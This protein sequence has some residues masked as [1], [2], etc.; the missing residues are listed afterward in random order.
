VSRRNPTVEEEDIEEAFKEE[1]H[2]SRRRCCVGLCVGTVIGV[3]VIVIILVVVYMV[4]DYFNKVPSWIVIPAFPL[5]A[6]K[7]PKT[8]SST[9]DNRAN[10]VPPPSNKV[11]LTLVCSEPYMAY[12]STDSC[13]SMC[14]PGEC[15][16]YEFQQ[17]NC[18]LNNLDTC[19]LYAPCQR[20]YSNSTST[21]TT[22]TIDIN[23]HQNK[24][25]GSNYNGTTTVVNASEKHRGICGR[26][27]TNS[28]I[29][30]CDPKMQVCASHLDCNRG[31]NHERQK[32]AVA[33]DA[34]SYTQCIWNTVNCSK[35]SSH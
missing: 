14:A 18:I 35:R 7:K 4:L 13:S 16:F 1:E 15:C 25:D 32:T 12:H 11:N 8:P 5:S 30:Y 23:S 22:E 2:D 33:D 29:L 17:G 19:G 21:A 3:A 28:S 34:W 24:T 20:Y 10:T 9:L 27:M 6:Q 31:N 26:N